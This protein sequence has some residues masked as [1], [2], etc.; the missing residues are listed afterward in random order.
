MIQSDCYS[1]ENPGSRLDCCFILLSRVAH[2][3]VFLEKRDKAVAIQ[4]LAKGRDVGVH[5][6]HVEKTV[7]EFVAD[8]TDD[9][10]VFAAAFGDQP[11]RIAELATGRI[12]TKP[13]PW[14]QQARRCIATL[15]VFLE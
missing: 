6:P 3:R 15:E 1:E 10:Q 5:K 2:R 11:E 13:A 8:T 4:P 12:V 7:G 9:F 14:L